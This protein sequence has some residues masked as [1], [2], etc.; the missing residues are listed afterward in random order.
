VQ[1]LTNAS[2]YYLLSNL[3]EEGDPPI[4]WWTKV[5]CPE[6]ADIWVFA[7]KH[8]QY[9]SPLQPNTEVY[10]ILITSPQPGGS[11][12]YNHMFI[13]EGSLWTPLE[14]TAGKLRDSSAKQIQK[15]LNKQR[16]GEEKKKAQ[17]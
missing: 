5:T 8:P 15:Q 4:G 17:Q 10:H 16:K 13:P 2:K 7:K 14:Q 12:V 6:D 11:M 3:P 1:L 9:F